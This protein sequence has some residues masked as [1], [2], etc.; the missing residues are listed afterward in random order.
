MKS[1]L[2]EPRI[3]DDLA[4]FYSLWRDA[5]LG[6]KASEV[7]EIKFL[8]DALAS[9][10]HIKSVIDLGGNVGL[11]AIALAKHGFDVTLLDRAKTA[12]T[13]AKRTSP[14]L[15][16]VHA[17][18]ESIDLIENFDAGFSMLSSSSYL[19]EESERKAFYEW[20][21]AH[22]N[23]LAIFDQI[24]ILRL[25]KAYSDNCQAEDKHF[26]FNVLREWHFEEDLLHTSF[27]YEFVDKAS[28]ATKIINDRQVQKFLTAE[29]LVKYMGKD[30][31]IVA[32]L[33]DCNLKQPFDQ[34][35]SPRMIAVFKKQ[36][37]GSKEQC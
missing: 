14:E 19:L 16:T 1:T 26:R 12:L 17:S 29:E 24:N 35:N 37:A 6:K 25:P 32:L 22:I 18:F 33:G 2:T 34:E 13:I 5:C 4:E 36:S 11:H 7:D 10:S 28:E 3:H 8:L 9:S 20:I 27:V 15:K 31:R 21:K 30:W 23:D